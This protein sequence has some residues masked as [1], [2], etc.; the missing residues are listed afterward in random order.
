MP[1][2]PALSMFSYR[3]HFQMRTGCVTEKIFAFTGSGY[4]E[5]F[6]RLVHRDADR[7]IT[8]LSIGP[9]AQQVRIPVPQVV[10]YPMD[11]HIEICQAG[12]Q[13]DNAVDML[14]TGRDNEYFVHDGGNSGS[15]QMGAARYSEVNQTD[16]PGMT[17]KASACFRSWA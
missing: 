12:E 7:H 16:F 9:C 5:Y 6:A 10:G 8:P 2:T 15:A 14:S 4:P 1:K 11:R 3:Q 13:S 17:V